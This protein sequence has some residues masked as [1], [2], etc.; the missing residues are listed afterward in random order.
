MIMMHNLSMLALRTGGP[1]LK[2]TAEYP[3]KFCKKVMKLH[4]QFVES[5]QHE[6]YC[7]VQQN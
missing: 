5:G 4:M 6:L 3:Q 1:K 2:Q 7:Y